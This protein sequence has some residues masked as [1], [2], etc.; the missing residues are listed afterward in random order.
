MRGSLVIFSLSGKNTLSCS[1]AGGDEPVFVI[2]TIWVWTEWEVQNSCVDNLR[3][4]KVTF[5]GINLLQA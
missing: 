1:V 3:P 4:S 2:T 5:P